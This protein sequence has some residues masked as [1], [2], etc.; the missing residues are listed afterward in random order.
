MGVD[1]LMVGTA[2]GGVQMTASSGTTGRDFVV[3]YARTPHTASYLGLT[4]MIGPWNP[5]SRRF[6]MTCDPTLCGRFEA[7]MTAIDLGLNSESRFTPPT[8]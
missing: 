5:P 7:P 8:W 1:A 2:A 6:V 3:G 4:G